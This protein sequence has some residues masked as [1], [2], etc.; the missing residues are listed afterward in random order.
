MLEINQVIIDMQTIKEKIMIK[1]EIYFNDLTKEAQE[2]YQGMI[3]EINQ[4][5]TGG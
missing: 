3:D 2:R 5:L 1:F 4:Q